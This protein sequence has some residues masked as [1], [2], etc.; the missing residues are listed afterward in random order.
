MV[1][2][3]RVSHLLRIR[4]CGWTSVEADIFT[5]SKG[6]LAGSV[7]VSLTA[8][9]V[10]C[11]LSKFVSRSRGLPQLSPTSRHLFSQKSLTSANSHPLPSHPLAGTVVYHTL[12]STCQAV[13]AQQGR[14]KGGSWKGTRALSQEG[15]GETKMGPSTQCSS[16]KTSVIAQVPLDETNCTRTFSFP[17]FLHFCHSL[18]A[19]PHHIQSRPTTKERFSR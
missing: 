9:E 6:R 1:P 15:E 17:S 11:C 5:C 7:C 18:G 13:A 4:Q 14:R 10:Q 19:K 3:R 8:L 2:K 12:S 16:S